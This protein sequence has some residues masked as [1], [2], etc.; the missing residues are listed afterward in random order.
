M[1]AVSA[2][3]LAADQS[4]LLEEVDALPATITSLHLDLEDGVQVPNFGLSL[5]SIKALP[6]SWDKDVHLMVAHPEQLIKLLQDCNITC[7]YLNIGAWNQRL[8]WSIVP[9]NVGLVINPTDD[10]LNFVKNIE[11][12]NNVLVMGVMPGKSGQKMLPETIARVQAI[13]KLN[14]TAQ[15]TVD[16]GVND[17]NAQFLIAAGANKLVIGSY[18]FQAENKEAAVKKLLDLI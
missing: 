5:E 9:S 8:S 12:A 7:F 3:L 11:E 15:L 14:P 18:L 6:R 4:R 1:I 2:S 10:V 16:G 13:R 17:S